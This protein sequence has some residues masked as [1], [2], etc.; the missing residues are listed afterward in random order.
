MQRV[1]HLHHNIQ[2]QALSGFDPGFG[3]CVP[4]SRTAC[5]FRGYTSQ[6]HYR[7]FTC[8]ICWDLCSI[9]QPPLMYSTSH[10]LLKT[11]ILDTKKCNYSIYLFLFLAKFWCVLA[12]LLRRLGTVCFKQ[13]FIN[14]I[15]CICLCLCCCV[16][17]CTW[18]QVS[19]G[20]KMLSGPLEMEFWVAVSHLTWVLG[21]ELGSSTRAAYTVVSSIF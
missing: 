16:G 3:N 12:T 19:R 13:D 5:G 14:V 9:L 10:T 8:I 21:T 17:V 15:M 6:H 2:R 20:H 7:V 4:N 18:M 11:W 1:H